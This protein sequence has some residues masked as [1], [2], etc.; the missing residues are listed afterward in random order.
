MTAG[1]F[2]RGNLL[3]SGEHWINYL[4]LPGG[5]SNTGMVSLYH[6]YYSPA[7]RGSVAYVDILDDPARAVSGFTAVCTDNRELARFI[8]ARMIRGNP[9]LKKS[10]WLRELPTREA[11]FSRGGDIQTEPS[12]T[13]D[14]G[15][16]RIVTTWSSSAAL[17]WPPTIH[18]QIVFT[19]LLFAEQAS[20]EVDGNEVAGEPYPNE[21]WSQSLGTPRSS[22]VFALAETMVRE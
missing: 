16:R 8:D 1:K 14:T 9:Y 5:E 2:S 22:C 18:P 20:I 15:D 12:W 19:T 10:P 3:W 21:A 17:A 11:Q 7:G 13:I 6:G 4:R